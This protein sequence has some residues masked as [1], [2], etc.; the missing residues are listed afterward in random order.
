M[1]NLL[2]P[3]E[4]IIIQFW[5]SASRYYHVE[6][7]V[8]SRFEVPNCVYSKETRIYI[9][10]KWIIKN[11]KAYTRKVYFRYWFQTI[12]WSSVKG[13]ENLTTED[14]TALRK[15]SKT[16]VMFLHGA[17]LHSLKEC[18][19]PVSESKKGQPA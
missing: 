5:W 13:F 2:L 3:Y 11:T 14:Q 10:I 6:S 1:F 16:E 17:Q 15:G 9:R 4:S 12:M 8:L 7:R 19:S 18:L